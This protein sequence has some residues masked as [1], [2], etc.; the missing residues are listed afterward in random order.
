M[1]NHFWLLHFFHSLCP[2]NCQRIPIYSVPFPFHIQASTVSCLGTRSSPWVSLHLGFVHWYLCIG[3][4]VIFL[5]HQSQ[6]NHAQVILFHGFP[7]SSYF[8]WHIIYPLWLEPCLPLQVHL[9]IL[10]FSHVSHCLQLWSLPHTFHFE[11][12]TT[13]GLHV[14]NFYFFSKNI[15]FYKAICVHL[16][17]SI[18]QDFRLPHGA[19]ITTSLYTSLSLHIPVSELS[20]DMLMFSNT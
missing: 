8:T 14:T 20:E 13:H 1:L 19:I 17:S 6:I 10:F 12:L 2:I 3:T 9:Q 5:K 7:S 4:K 11:C 18:P 16:R 15:T